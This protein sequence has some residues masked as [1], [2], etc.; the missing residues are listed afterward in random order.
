MGGR[1]GRAPTGVGVPRAVLLDALG[2]LVGLDEPFARLALELDGRG[3]PI[4]S[5]AAREALLVEM[6]YY[7]AHHDEAA[8]PRGLEGLHDRCAEVLRTALPEPARSLPVREVRAAML[9]AIRFQPYPE[10]PGVL[11]RLRAGG[12]RLVV[13]SNWDVSL[14]GVL[15][16]TGLAPLV[17]AVLTSAELGFAK[18][19]KRIFA[20]ALELAGVGAAQALHVG[21][22]VR[23]DARGARAAGIAAVLVD[24]DGS[25]TAPPGVRAVRSL[26]GLLG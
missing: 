15:A 10:V 8:D 11:A 17:D 21:D 7:R 24:R 4:G 9:A 5:G 13:V 14:H 16:E 20:R 1:L 25:L 18:P 12:A 23:A 22:D 3:T 19:D 2:T 26:D 6:A